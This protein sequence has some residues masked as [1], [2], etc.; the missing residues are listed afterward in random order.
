MSERNISRSSQK[1]TIGLIVNPVAGIGG[2]AALKGSDGT[3]LYKQASELG[4]ESK[5]AS[6]VMRT[7]SMLSSQ[8]QDIQV[9]TVSGQMGGDLCQE[10]SQIQP[11][12]EYSICHETGVKGM[13]TQ[14]A[15]TLEAVRQ[16]EVSGVDIIVFAGGDGTARNVHDALGRGSQ[17]LVLGIP[18]G[19]KMHSGVFAVTPEA[20]GIV[21]QQ[22]VQGELVSVVQR[23]VKDIDEEALRA[24]TV[25]SKYYGEMWVPEEHRYI[26]AV[27]Q[28]GL[29]V[30][31]LVLE[32]IASNIIEQMEP[33]EIYVVGAGTTTAAIMQKLGFSNTLLG[34]DVIC[35]ESLV[36]EDAREDE[37]YGYLSA[38]YLGQANPVKLLVTPIGGQGHLFGRGNQQL[39]ARVLKVIGRKNFVV[40]AT[41]SKLESLGQ[42]DFIEAPKSLNMDGA[43]SETKGIRLLVDTGEIELDRALCGLIPVIS[44]YE[45]VVICRL[46]MN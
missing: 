15:D 44:G 6:R 46:A 4:Y 40:V 38:N 10:L 20:A 27:K 9:R 43:T 21:L 1:L 35:D 45:D 5:V 42:H 31:A 33:G 12:L 7:L 17:Q 11:S 8:L 22:L 24:G 3:G 29:E 16:I 36:L 37:L 19:V 34:V 13:E 23:E 25:N 28:G 2:P 14:V 18:C 32:E 30:E 41:K 39:S 26:Q